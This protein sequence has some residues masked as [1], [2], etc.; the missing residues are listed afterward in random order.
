M[1][2][3]LVIGDDDVLRHADMAAAIE[4]VERV[5]DAT[6][7]SFTSPPRHRVTFSPGTDLVLTMGGSVQIGGVG[8]VRSYY[9]KYSKH[10]DDQVVAVWDLATGAMRGLV[11]GSA[12]SALRMGAIGGAT[13]RRLTPPQPLTVAIIGTGRQAASHLEAIAT[14][15]PVRDARVYGR[16]AEKALTLCDAVG[17]RM[18]ASPAATPRDAVEGADVVIL[19]TTSLKPLISADWLKDTAVVHTVGFKSPAG[20]EMGLDVPAR[21][22]LIVTD[23]MPQVEAS[24]DKF[25]LAGTDYI[26]RIKSLHELPVNPKHAVLTASY[27][28][29]LAGTEILIADWLLRAVR[30]A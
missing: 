8:G 15:R 2:A 24:G 4:E 23:S 3:P 9:T 12:L 19:A 20:K 6:G 30:D 1:S 11:L 25:V 14:V 26:K 10:S 22:A 21:A 7:S 29:G 5:L 28:M 13:F 27:P 17:E 16:S 18:S